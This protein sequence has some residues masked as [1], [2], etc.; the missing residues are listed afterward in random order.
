[1]SVSPSGRDASAFQQVDNP[2]RLRPP[3]VFFQQ[4]ISHLVSSGRHGIRT[5]IPVRRHALAVRPGEPYPATF[6]MSV[7][8]P[9]VELGLPPR[10]GGVVPLDHEPVCLVACFLSRALCDVHCV[11]CTVSSSG[12]DGSRTHH[13]DLA[14]VSRPQRHA[15][16]QLRLLTFSS[17]SLPRR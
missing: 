7:D 12:P 13:T 9:R 6:R 4:Q 15:G 8:P 10:Q 5:H 3:L 16:P 11:D 2:A 14:R 17:L 1:M